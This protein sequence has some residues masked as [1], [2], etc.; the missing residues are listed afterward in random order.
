MPA[1][2]CGAEFALVS[3]GPGK[4]AIEESPLPCVGPE[5]AGGLA[6]GGTGV[7]GGL[8][9]GVAVGTGRG[10]GVGEGS[11]VGVGVGVG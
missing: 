5:D 4:P 6:G 9:I 8:G 2:L 10:V 3:P 7:L 1:L 11:G